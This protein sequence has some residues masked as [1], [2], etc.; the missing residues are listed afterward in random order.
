M[1]IDLII[2]DGEVEEEI[3]DKSRKEN[4]SRKNNTISKMKGT[5]IKEKNRII[6]LKRNKKKKNIL[7]LDSFN[8]IYKLLIIKKKQFSNI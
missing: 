1:K 5:L 7:I 4:I 8:H 2:I 6:N 3:K